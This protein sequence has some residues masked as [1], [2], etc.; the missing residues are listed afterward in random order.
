MTPLGI[1][2]VLAV[3]TAFALRRGFTRLIAVAAGFPIGVIASVGG[4][5]AP[6]FFTLGA[7]ACLWLGVEWIAGRGRVRDG[8]SEHRPG[9]LSLVIFLGWSLLVTLIA[10]TVFEGIPVLVA[11]GGIDEQFLDPGTLTYTVSNVAQAAYLVISI[12]VV[13]FLA[14]SPA[15]TPGLLGIVLGIITV[16]SFWR[17]LS[18]GTGLPYPEGF[19]D[20]ST[21]VRIIEETP[22]GEA[23]FRGIFSEPSG[24]AAASLTTL[25]FFALRLRYL[26]GW[27]RVGAVAILVMAA[28]NAASS[29]AGTFVAA[30]LIM[31][32]IVVVFWIG[33]FVVN[34]TRLDPVLAAVVILVS[35]VGLFFVPTLIAFVESVVSV[36]ISSS[37][38]GS[39]TG[40]DLFSYLLTLDTWGFGVGL[41]SNRP[42]SFLATLLS[43]TGVIGAAFFA[44]AITRLIVA[45]SAKPEYHAT[46]WA[47]VSVLVSKIVSSP[48]ISD[49][50]ALLWISCGVLAHAAWSENR[51]A[52]PAPGPPQRLSL[53]RR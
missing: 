52:E 19:F 28:V 15:T 38:Y 14:K 8:S 11:R 23:R 35:G 22:D 53:M 6:T 5:P 31:V 25:V 36:K 49:N 51:E 4:Q 37:S 40:V 24:L 44:I 18:L 47:L 26:G 39:R 27:G 20:N 3:L 45:A 43:C 13:F 42:S 1:V 50:A 30:G 29:T 10:P 48:N 32:G 46:I 17:L 7:L 41:G 9:A 12:G 2:L 16:V 33:G 21:T 34:R